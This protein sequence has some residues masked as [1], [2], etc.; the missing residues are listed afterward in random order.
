VATLSTAWNIAQ[1]ALEANQ[2]AINISANNAANANTPGYTAK[3]VTWQQTDTFTSNGTIPQGVNV[4]GSTAQR[5]RV[6]NGRIDLAAQDSAGSQ[7]RL[8]ALNDVQSVF[9][10]S[11]S[12]SGSAG[13]STDIGQQL[14]NFFNSLSQLAGGPTN[15]SLRSGVLAAAQSLA[16]SFNRTAQA[17]TGQQASL[18]ATAGNVA[19]E[20]NS[21]TKDIAQL[22]G[23]IA[24]LSPGADAGS[25]EDQRQQDLLN[26]SQLVGNSQITTEGNGITVTTTSGAV[27]VDGSRS[28]DLSVSNGAGGARFLV[29]QV[30]VTQQLAGGGGQLGGILTARDTDIPAV[31]GQLDTLASAIGGAINAKQVAGTDAAGQPGAPMF[32]LPAGVNGSAAAITV[33]LSDPSLIAA[34]AGGGGTGDGSN[35]SAMADLQSGAVV[36]G[37]KP[38]DFYAAMVATVGNLVGGVSTDHASQQASLTQLQTQQSALSSVNLDEEAAHLQSYEQAY[39]AASKVFSILNTIM[40][41]AINLGTQTPV[42]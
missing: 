8:N 16:A 36:S 9:S 10:T 7:A 3:T 21:L 26:L 32:G 35:A 29:G 6:L 27:L 14:S 23:Q 15:S 41:S 30:D 17:L 2:A 28:T 42:A 1:S 4:T 22:N 20:V 37:A 11:L 25:L 39:Q 18:S 31:L 40:A 13:Q 38:S 5:D 24:S 33:N 12:N 19:G 34:G